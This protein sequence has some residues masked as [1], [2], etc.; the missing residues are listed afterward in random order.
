M[1]GAAALAGAV[2]FGAKVVLGFSAAPG[3]LADLLGEGS[4]LQ[5]PVAA[6][7]TAGAFGVAYLGVAHLWKVGVPLRKG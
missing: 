7:G 5:N 6:V 3:I 2:G 4:V 1:V